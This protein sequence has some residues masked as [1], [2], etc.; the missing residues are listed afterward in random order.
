MTMGFFLLLS[1]F[2]ILLTAVGGLTFTRLTAIFLR[3]R[4][5]ALSVATKFGSVLPAV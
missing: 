4:R 3:Y 5:D 1:C 2:F